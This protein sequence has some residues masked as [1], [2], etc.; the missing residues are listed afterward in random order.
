MAVAALGGLSSAA[1]SR[2][3]RRAPCCHVAA[4]TVVKVELVDQVSSATQKR[5]A[6]FALRLAAP[7][8][9]DGQVVLRK[10]S[11]GVGE[12][13]DSTPPGLGGKPATMV[14]AADYLET[15]RGKL[16][17]DALQLARS[18]QD[19]STT[20]HVLGISGIV[21]APLGLA[22]I[23]VQGGQVVFNPGVVATA[24]VASDMTLPPLARASR[25]DI[26]AAGS[27]GGADLDTAGPIAIAP[28]PPGQGQVVFFRAKTL[29]G[30]G[31]WFNVRENGKALGKLS[32]GAYFVQPTDPGMHTYTAVL[33]P[34]FKD[35]LKLRVDPGETYF[36]QGTIAG[37][38]VIGAADLTPS[39]RTA[40]NAAAKTLTLATAPDADK[41]TGKAGGQPADAATGAP[42]ATPAGDAPSSG[43]SMATSAAGA[44]APTTTPTPTT[45]N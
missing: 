43:S 14:L 1:Q 7:L 22:G 31:Q 37:G 13:V 29:M 23:V 19:N 2:A 41:P 28:P 32:N 9:V 17:L 45:P 27:Q 4:G 30:S 24:K 15:R 12:V 34:E 5:G 42:N 44:A 3:P 11:R 26:A 6:T 40:F 10:G 35:K 33:E 39:D 20:S 8:I 16:Q 36:V 21:F 25:R 38:L 18:G